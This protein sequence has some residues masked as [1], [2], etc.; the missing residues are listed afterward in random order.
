ML[1]SVYIHF[2][3]KFSCSQ[4]LY[5]LPSRNVRRISMCAHML[6]LASVVY[7]TCSCSAFRNF[8]ELF[9]WKWLHSSISSFGAGMLL[10]IN[11]L[12]AQTTALNSYQAHSLECRERSIVALFLCLQR[13][14]QLAFCFEI[15][16]WQMCFVRQFASGFGSN[17]EVSGVSAGKVRVLP[18]CRG[19]F[20][21]GQ[22]LVLTLFGE[23]FPLAWLR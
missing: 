9:V 2:P 1:A 8:L 13:H 5:T 18:Y 4:V 14:V 22:A 7:T 20:S 3:L 17:G 21:W 19:Y 16:T 10:S 11:Y 23:W 6:A 12:P 15:L